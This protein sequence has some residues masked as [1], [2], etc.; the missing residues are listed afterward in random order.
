ME[1]VEVQNFPTSQTHA[2][3]TTDIAFKKLHSINHGCDKNILLTL[4]NS[5]VTIFREDPVVDILEIPTK[6]SVASHIVEKLSFVDYEGRTA[7]GSRY[8]IEIQSQLDAVVEESALFHWCG[9]YTRQLS[10]VSMNPNSEWYTHLKPVIILQFCN[11]ASQTKSQIHSTTYNEFFKHY[12]LSEKTTTCQGGEVEHLHVVQIDMSRAE[13]SQ[14]LFPP[15]SVSNLVKDFTEKSID[16]TTHDQMEEGMST[17]SSTGTPPEK[18]FS[19]SEWWMSILLHAHDYTNEMIHVL[20]TR[21]EL[22]PQIIQAFQQLNINRWNPLE[23]AIYLEELASSNLYQVLLLQE[24]STGRNQGILESAM[25]L[26]K[27][28]AFQEQQVIEMLELTEV[29]VQMLRNS[30]DT[31]HD[32]ASNH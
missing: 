6:L 29:E 30:L 7:Q 26:L 31:E 4:L 23:K 22:P 11:Y 1:I 25:K 19:F 28:K 21:N 5:F 9:A 32:R 10:T 24:R 16:S 2:V 13:A 17:N 3:A 8:F 15:A 20:T 14:S 27:N 12:S 18:T